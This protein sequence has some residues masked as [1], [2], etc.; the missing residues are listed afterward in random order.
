MI[1]GSEL[2]T[3]RSNSILNEGMGVG[4]DELDTRVYVSFDEV[5]PIT[6]LGTLRR[7]HVPPSCSKCR[8]LCVYLGSVSTIVE[9]SSSSAP[10]LTGS[11][12]SVQSDQVDAKSHNQP[13]VTCTVASSSSSP[14][15]C[16][17]ASMAATAQQ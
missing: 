8:Y 17:R 10:P 16:V 4:L 6:C 1:G 7:A 9:T 14:P 3:D 15:S 2:V 13:I 12:L 5:L 11:A